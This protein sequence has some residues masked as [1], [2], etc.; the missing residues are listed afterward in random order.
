MTAKLRQG[1]PN[2]C[3]VGMHMS[4]QMMLK[5][6][7]YHTV[8]SVSSVCKTRSIRQANAY[9]IEHVSNRNYAEA[10]PPDSRADWQGSSVLLLL[11][12]LQKG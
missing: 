10:A 12:P 5:T 6:A 11:L 8:L 1:F 4:P 9:K 2:P 3:T 7:W